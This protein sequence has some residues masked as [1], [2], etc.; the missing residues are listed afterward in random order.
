MKAVE[1]AIFEDFKKWQVEKGDGGRS[2]EDINSF[3]EA[4]YGMKIGEGNIFDKVKEMALPPLSPESAK[5]IENLATCTKPNSV[6]NRTKRDASS[7]YAGNTYYFGDYSISSLLYSDCSSKNNQ[8]WDSDYILREKVEHIYD[9]DSWDACL[10]LCSAWKGPNNEICDFWQYNS[11]NAG[12]FFFFS[13]SSACNPP[14]VLKGG[15][16]NVWSGRCPPPS[17]SIC[18]DGIRY[19]EP[20]NI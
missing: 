14:P 18:R 8:R 2:I 6:Y 9:V 5:L 3:M 7:R 4:E 19:G 12:C 1:E 10:D 13:V 11:F 16:P 17:D 15:Y 20:T